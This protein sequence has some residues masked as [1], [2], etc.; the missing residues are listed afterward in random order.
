M[1]RKHV[2]DG[3]D[4][5]KQE[6]LTDGYNLSVQDHVSIDGEVKIDWRKRQ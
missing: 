1:C 3:A 2:T 6:S 5:T 4:F